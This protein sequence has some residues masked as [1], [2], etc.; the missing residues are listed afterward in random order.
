MKKMIIVIDDKGKGWLTVGG[1]CARIM[2][3]KEA[4]FLMPYY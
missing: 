4:L 1:G 2:R 3:L